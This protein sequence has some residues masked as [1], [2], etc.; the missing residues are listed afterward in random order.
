MV[1]DRVRAAI[2]WVAVALLVYA[3][4]LTVKPFLAPLAWAGVL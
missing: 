1:G 4:A 3:A 2:G